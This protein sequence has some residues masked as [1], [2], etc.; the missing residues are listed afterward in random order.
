MGGRRKGV[1]GR[2]EEGSEWEGRLP[3]S[4]QRR[5]HSKYTVGKN[6]YSLSLSQT[7]YC[8]CVSRSH[9]DEDCR[10]V[11]FRGRRQ[12][13][14]CITCKF[15]RWKGKQRL[16]RKALPGKQLVGIEPT[17]PQTVVELVL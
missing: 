5:S 12:L 9:L 11:A 10:V 1:N 13:G 16:W 3:K 6:S 17:T 7:A 14:A 8:E 2:E 4:S 15:F